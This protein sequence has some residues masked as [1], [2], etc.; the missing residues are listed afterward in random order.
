MKVIDETSFMETFQYFDKSIVVE[1]I[2]IFIDEYPR[3]M[4]DLKNDIDKKDFQKLKFDAHSMKGVIANFFA[5]QP[6]KHA[7]DL[8][9]KGVES[10]PS[11]LDEIYHNLTLAGADLL[12]DLKAIKPRFASV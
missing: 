4:S 3:R 12:E 8:E 1:I 5:A 7:K 9:M 6:Q 2:D 10:D 11:N